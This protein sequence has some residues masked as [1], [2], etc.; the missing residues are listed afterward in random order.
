M[1]RL[2]SVLL[3]LSMLFS[4]V[5]CAP[6]SEPSSA[7]FFLMD[8]VITV[9]LYAD[10]TTASPILAECRSILA[11][12][13]ALWS[14]TREESDTSRFNRADVGAVPADARTVELLRVALDVSNH[15]KGAFDVTVAPLVLLWQACEEAGRLPNDGEL[16]FAMAAIGADAITPAGDFLKKNDA[17][18][19]IDLGGIGKG[20]AISILLSYLSSTG[21][22]G[23]LVSFGSN[24]AVFG[25]KPN[26]TEFRIALRDPKDAN[27]YAGTL[28]LCDGEVLS[29]SGDYERFYLI[30]GKQYHHILDPK[31]GYPSQSGLSSVAVIC[32]DGALAD[33]LSTALLVMGEEAARTFHASGRYNFD[34]VFITED[35]AVSATDGIRFR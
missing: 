18:A 11:E 3:L 21:V 8:T 29:V 7:S 4:L 28:A 10:A 32:R 25:K 12:L 20:A 31:T 33:A 24:V 35:G 26:G 15:T 34:A 22:E 14:R 1:R 27:S 17:H 23:G 2:L 16:A 13:D 9:T 30:D 5:S 19:K 6:S